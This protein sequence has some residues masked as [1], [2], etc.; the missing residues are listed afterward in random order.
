MSGLTGNIVTRSRM[1]SASIWLALVVS[2][3]VFFS[4]PCRASWRA[5][6][7]KLTIQ[8]P[9]V[10]GSK[11]LPIWTDCTLEGIDGE[12]HFYFRNLDG[13]WGR[14]TILKADGSFDRAILPPIQ[15]HEKLL[16]RGW[17][18]Q[19]HLLG[20]SGNL[21]V[22]SGY[23]ED[24]WC[25]YNK[26]GRLVRTI[27]VLCGLY[28]VYIYP[29][30]RF[31][32]WVGEGR[33]KTRPYSKFAHTIPLRCVYREF[34][35]NGNFV[36]LLNRP[37][38]WYGDTQVAEPYQ[39]KGPSLGIMLPFEIV[40]PDVKY[41]LAPGPTL[42]GGAHKTHLGELIVWG[43][44]DGWSCFPLNPEGLDPHL[45][46]EKGARIGSFPYQKEWRAEKERLN[47]GLP[48]GYT[49]ESEGV[50]I[51][52]Q[53][54]IWEMLSNPNGFYI[55]KIPWVDEPP[56]TPPAK[57]EKL[58]GFGFP[59]ETSPMRGAPPFATTAE[60]AQLHFV[61]GEQDIPLCGRRFPA[62][63]LWDY[64][65]ALYQR[66]NPGAVMGK[67]GDHDPVRDKDIP[68]KPLAWVLDLSK[69]ATGQVQMKIPF[70]RNK[71]TWDLKR[72]AT[73]QTYTLNCVRGYEPPI[74]F[75]SKDDSW[76]LSFTPR[77]DLIPGVSYFLDLD[78]KKPDIITLSSASIYWKGPVLLYETA[79]DSKEFVPPTVMTYATLEPKG[80]E[81]DKRATLRVHSVNWPD[82]L[83][84]VN[85]T[86]T[87]PGSRRF[88]NEDGSII[89]ELAWVMDELKHLVDGPGADTS[90]YLYFYITDPK[91]G[92]NRA[93][94]I[95]W[96]TG[97][98]TGEYRSWAEPDSS[99][100]N[101]GEGPWA[102]KPWAQITQELKESQ[103]TVEVS[104]PGV[105]KGSKLRVLWDEPG[106]GEVHE[107]ID[108]QPGKDGTFI[109]TKPLLC[110]TLNGCDIGGTWK[111]TENVPTPQIP[112]VVTFRENNVRFSLVNAP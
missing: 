90:N 31:V 24:Q 107:D 48:Q 106:K 38:A 33:T 34:D 47:Q 92:L 59:P 67:V 103:F 22:K 11:T 80:L 76:Y 35:K 85:L 1:K 91:L 73:L 79:A 93:P 41:T 32:I 108:L 2:I 43:A 99:I 49:R 25:I 87:A 27:D 44:F 18:I 57:I 19:V 46:D 13:E 68:F 70:R 56:E 28:T 36:R 3:S 42:I 66:D 78:P 75:H 95:V 97:V 17:P 74:S 30:G 23:Q 100:I 105:T 96:E 8:D 53:R 45:Y 69:L 61:Y 7:L 84:T 9:G 98:D 94:Q 82:R 60:G 111:E 83:D 62:Y 51:D 109:T 89:Y 64:E 26:E 58:D 6:E 39:G 112:G 110:F 55:Y 52:E 63:S 37:P 29:D 102:Y 77:S 86:E 101:G 81:A 10:F 5:F 14:I 104:G 15:W 21:L 12:G 88:V 54:N 72:T 71:R 16:M 40:F 4:L 20:T 50:A 65:L